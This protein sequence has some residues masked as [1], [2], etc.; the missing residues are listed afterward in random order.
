MGVRP[1]ADRP[2]RGHRRLWRALPAGLIDSGLASLAT[3]LVGVFAA[4]RLPVDVLG[5]Y[6]LFFSAFVVAGVVP[7]RLVLLPVEVAV[8]DQPRSA[9]PTVLRRSLALG[10]ATSGAS[11]GIVAIAMLAVPG[12]V[13][14]QAVAALAVGAA[15]ATVLS[16]LQ[17]HVRRVLHLAGRSWRAAI[18]SL[19]QLAAVL[20]GLGVL[21][22]TPLPLAAVPFGALAAANAVSLGAGLL[23][24]RPGAAPAFARALR[25]RELVRSGRW[26]LASGLMPDG[27]AFVA[28]ALV[29]HLAS[30]GALGAAEAARI[31]AQPLLV[32]STGLAAVLSPRSMESAAA[33]DRRAARRYERVFCAIVVGAAVAYA[34]A[35][36]ADSPWNLF[37]ALFAAAYDVPGLVALAIA[38]NLVH[39]LSIPYQSELVAGRREVQMAGRE[40]AGVGAH[41]AVA[42]AA[43]VLQAHAKPGAALAHSAVRWLGYRVERERLYRR[44][45]QRAAASG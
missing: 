15:A 36:G 16:P 25:W 44:D 17:D 2:E 29:A 30:V 13:E 35:V 45:P 40:A 5:A 1:P 26:L 21:S 14:P 37:G 39:A 12:V 10:A 28:A 19:V 42:A 6:A 23:L 33:G 11:V 38:A 41:I 27:A 20:A 9:R 3:F 34:L 22:R 4:T 31:V 18:V 8:L 7:A 32:L 24:A 43:P